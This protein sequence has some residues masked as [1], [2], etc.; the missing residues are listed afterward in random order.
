MN[1]RKCEFV[2]ADAGERVHATEMMMLET[3]GFAEGE[4]APTTLFPCLL[5]FLSPSLIAN[6]ATTAKS[7]SD[8]ASHCTLTVPLV[9]HRFFT[10]VVAV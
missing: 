5:P 1:G 9:I 3:A 8:D 4:A 2:V 10:F 7:Q 6:S